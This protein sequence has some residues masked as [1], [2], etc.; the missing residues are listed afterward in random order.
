MKPV[1]YQMFLELQSHIFCLL[2]ITHSHII[3][4]ISGDVI[5]GLQLPVTSELRFH[6]YDRHNHAKDGTCFVRHVTADYHGYT[7]K[8]KEI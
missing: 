4:V 3:P 6:G 5:I 2:T 1:L 8:E 7:R